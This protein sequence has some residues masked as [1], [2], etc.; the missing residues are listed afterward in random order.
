MTDDSSLTDMSAQQQSGEGCGSTERP[1]ISVNGSAD[2][3]V[4]PVADARKEASTPSS[5]AKRRQ[6]RKKS[7]IQL[8]HW[9]SSL[10]SR[11]SQR[12]GFLNLKKRG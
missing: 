6:K 4:S 8:K 9:R 10:P 7:L 5:P 2:H 12:R 3:Q 11:L 1:V